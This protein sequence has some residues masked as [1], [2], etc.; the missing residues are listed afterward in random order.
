MENVVGTGTCADTSF[1]A[2]GSIPA[3][4]SS[5]TYAITKLYP[6][7]D[8]TCFDPP[9]DSNSTYKYRAEKWVMNGEFTE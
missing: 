7:V 6:C 8:F 5:S 3:M 1:T 4:R 9:L 2:K